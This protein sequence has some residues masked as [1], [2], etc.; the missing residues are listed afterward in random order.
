[1]ETILFAGKKNYKFKNDKYNIE[2]LIN[3]NC[4]LYQPPKDHHHTMNT[5]NHGGY[6]FVIL[7]KS[8]LICDTE[9]TEYLWKKLL[10]TIV[11]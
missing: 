7:S 8:N 5:G 11:I 6:G 9:Y 2:F 3:R 1:M 4:V 10:L